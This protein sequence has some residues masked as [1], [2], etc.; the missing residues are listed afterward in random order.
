[1]GYKCNFKNLKKIILTKEKNPE[2]SKYKWLFDTKEN[3]ILARDVKNYAIQQYVCNVHSSTESLKEK[4]I[5]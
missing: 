5:K 1:M 3:K 4:Q 2:A